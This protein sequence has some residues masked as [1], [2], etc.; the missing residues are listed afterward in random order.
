M[1]VEKDRVRHITRECAEDQ[2]V[3]E[4]AEHHDLTQVPNDIIITNRCLKK[5]KK[6]IRLMH[7]IRSTVTLLPLVQQKKQRLLSLSF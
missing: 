3:S 7:V 4:Y 1:V 5:R 6:I 2:H